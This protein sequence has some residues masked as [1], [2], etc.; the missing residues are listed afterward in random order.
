MLGLNRIGYDSVA[1]AWDA[2]RVCFYGR[3]RDYLDAFLA[4]VPTPSTIVDLPTS[5]SRP[6]CTNS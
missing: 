2:A 5:A 6:S 1:E 3:E 4:D